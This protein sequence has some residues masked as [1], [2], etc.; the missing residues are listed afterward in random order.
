MLLRLHIQN[1]ALIDQLTVDFNEGFSTLTG[2]TGAGKSILLGALA[3]A[4][5]N[6][7]DTSAIGDAEKKCVVEAT[8]NVKPYRLESVFA[9]LDLDYQDETIVRRELLPNGKSRA[10]V[11]DT[12][13]NVN[14]LKTLGQYLID[15]HSQH[16]NLELNNNQFQLRVV[17]AAA[18][19]AD[20]LNDY[21]ETYR[22]YRKQQ[23]ELETLRD[24]ARRLSADYDYN[25]FQYN[26][27]A[28][29]A[30]E[31]INQQE[32][33]D[34]FQTLSNVVEIQQNL[35]A[36]V[37]LLQDGEQNLLSQLSQL[38]QTVQQVKRYFPKAADYLQRLESVI[39]EMKDF[40][41]EM[42]RDA[43]Q[44]E[45]QPERLEFLR[46][47]LDQL[48][49]LLQ[50]HQVADVEGLVRIKNEL[51]GKLGK[52]GNYELRI[53]QAEKL[54]AETTERL[55]GLATQL[56]E[57]RTKMLEPLSREICSHLTGLGM[58]NAQLRIDISE[59]SQ[60]TPTGCDCINFM[61]TANRN[62]EL[63]NISKIASG[64]EISR[65]MLSIKAILSASV[66]L[67][68]IIFDEIDTGV[69]G[70][71]AHKMAE[72]MSQMAEHMQVITITH[73]PQIAAKGDVQYRVV[74]RDVNG[75]TQTFVEQLSDGERVDEVARMLSGK[76]IT[77]EARENAK[78]LLNG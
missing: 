29:F 39:I 7:A 12:P 51:E 50:K 1:Y 36:A 57:R 63:Q 71:I 41:Q 30:P 68:T 69:S 73:L 18:K 54:L 23:T 42:D 3:L 46:S 40:A 67:P 34:E 43:Q 28:E 56:T 48:Y 44:L 31:K 22:N 70:D 14:N 32:M 60:F 19:N 52:S 38:R 2:E 37:Y 20:L 13:V 4:L 15:I 74:K 61:F 49:G 64:G 25:Q 45:N 58:P 11:N 5:G 55:K 62:R 66:A 33:E 65:L 53:E 6:R 16:E 17:D 75:T 47:K 59:S 76:D 78:S 72:L 10:F 24:E 26:Q 9:D 8:F 21:A 27:L 77:N 35:N